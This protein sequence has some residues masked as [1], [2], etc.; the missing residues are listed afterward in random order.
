[1]PLKKKNYNIFDPEIKIKKC[2]S[3]F[4]EITLSN[5]VEKDV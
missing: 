2:M 4:G 1:M 3:C 5:T